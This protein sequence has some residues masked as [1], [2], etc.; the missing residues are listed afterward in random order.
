MGFHGKPGPGRPKGRKNRVPKSFKAS[1][2]AVLELIATDDPAL[3]EKAVRRG[4][5]GRP[6]E[7]FPFIQLAA[8]YI[9]GKPADTIQVKSK[10]GAP[11]V[12]VLSAA[13]KK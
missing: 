1:I 3:I 6:R 4:L 7:S 2:K 8:H 9:D 10:T 12:V 5:N 13:V 11:C